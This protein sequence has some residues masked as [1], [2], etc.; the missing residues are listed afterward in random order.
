MTILGPCRHR[1]SHD[2]RCGITVVATPYGP[3][4]TSAPKVSHYPVVTAT[5]PHSA[6]QATPDANSGPVG[7]IALALA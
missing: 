7:Q 5:A 4:H 6:S 2:V 3:G 1:Y